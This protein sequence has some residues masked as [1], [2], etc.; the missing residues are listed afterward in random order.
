MKDLGVQIITLSPNDERAIE[1]V[2]ALL[3]E[4]F[5]AHSPNAWSNMAA[6]LEE[7]RESFGEDRISRIAVD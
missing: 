4:G 6:A 7:V 2:A 1:Q 3:S 5:K